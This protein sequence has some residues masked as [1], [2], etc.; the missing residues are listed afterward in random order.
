MKPGETALRASIR[1]MRAEPQDEL[2][3]S[4][5]D[6]LCNAFSE[7]ELKTLCFFLSINYDDLQGDG[8]LA[9]ARE[10]VKLYFNRDDLDTLRTAI[11]KRN[12]SLTL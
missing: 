3:L 4:L 7:E 6:A 2:K 8:K 10:L 11:R 1:K 12:A 5:Y 9:K